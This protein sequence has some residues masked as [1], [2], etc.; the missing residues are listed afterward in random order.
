M[1]VP[2][3]A[4]GL[5]STAD[6]LVRWHQALESGE[7]IGRS[8]LDRAWS[9][10]LLPDGV[11]SGYGFGWKVCELGG[12]RAVQH[13]GFINGFGAAAIHLPDDGFTVIVLV[14][15]D[16]DRPD[17]GALARRIGRTLTSGRP[18]PRYRSLTR[19]ERRALVGTYEVATDDVRTIVEENGRLF[20]RRDGA[21]LVPLEPLSATRLTPATSEG[22]ITWDFDLRP[23]GGVRTLRAFLSCEPMWSARRR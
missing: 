11:S 18:L 12:R 21:T 2:H 1:T 22:A 16:A 20:Y 14:N 8:L 23:D 17:A 9:S 4:G 7:V 15:Q 6:D 10:R 19:A 3:A 13:G 5:A